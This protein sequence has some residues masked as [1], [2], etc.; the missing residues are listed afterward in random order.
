MVRI[1][2]NRNEVCGEIR[3]RISSG[4]ACY[5]SV[6]ELSPSCLFYKMLKIRRYKMILPTDL[7]G[8][9]INYKCL[10]QTVQEVFGA[11]KNG[12]SEQFWILI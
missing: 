12:V 11:K 5:Y 6:L 1:Q 7:C 9:N 3:R 8:K 4:N 10:K 2:T